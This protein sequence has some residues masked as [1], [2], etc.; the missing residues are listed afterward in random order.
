MKGA[1]AGGMGGTGWKEVEGKKSGHCN[2]TINKTIKKN[3]Y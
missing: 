3:Y 2:S 1:I